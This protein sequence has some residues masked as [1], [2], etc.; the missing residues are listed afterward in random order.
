MPPIVGTIGFVLSEL[1]AHADLIEFVISALK[2]GKITK[3]EAKKA[4]TDSITAAYDVKV[5]VEM[6]LGP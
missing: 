1:V 3:D 4:I 5:K 2:D 6:G